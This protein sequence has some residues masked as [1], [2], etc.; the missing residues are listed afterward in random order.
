M[1]LSLISVTIVSYT[2][3]AVAW[4]CDTQLTPA[5]ILPRVGSLF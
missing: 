4:L 1:K 2:L 3:L 5:E